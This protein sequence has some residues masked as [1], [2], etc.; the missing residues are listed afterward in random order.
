VRCYRVG[1]CR[2][3]TI[4]GGQYLVLQTGRQGNDALALTVF[5][6]I[7]ETAVEIRGRLCVRGRLALLHQLTEHALR[8][9]VIN[10]RLCPRELIARATQKGIDIDVIT[11]L[12]AD[13]VGKQEPETVGGFLR[14]ILELGCRGFSG[15]CIGFAL[16]GSETKRSGKQQRAAANASAVKSMRRSKAGRERTR[17]TLSKLF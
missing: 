17:N 6:Q 10:Q 12:T 3:F 14:I 13:I 11:E 8:L 5:F 15:R 9:G 16:A 2:L 1:C 7:L 4:L